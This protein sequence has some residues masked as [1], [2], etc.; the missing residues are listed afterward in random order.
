MRFLLYVATFS[1]VA[2]CASRNPVELSEVT[3]PSREET[4]DQ[5]ICT[6]VAGSEQW[7]CAPD[8]LELVKL[9]RELGVEDVDTLERTTAIDLSTNETVTTT[10]A[11]D[12]THDTEPRT[13]VQVSDTVAAV[14]TAEPEDPQE[15]IDQPETIAVA[16]DSDPV[17]NTPETQPAS[18]EEVETTSGDSVLSNSPGTWLVQVASFRTTDRAKTFIDSNRNYTFEKFKVRVNEETFYSLIL[19]ETFENSLAAVERAESLS[20]N[21]TTS[22]PW[23]RTVRSLKAV[24][25]E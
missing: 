14:P 18:D 12:T 7:Y 5:W 25:I 17:E 24:L 6:G 21:Q 13:T 22:K 11:P 23:V 3:E 15:S 9:I 1:L 2:G 19:A 16:T 4:S 10:S 20:L 8:E